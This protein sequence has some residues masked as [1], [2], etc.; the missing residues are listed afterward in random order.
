MPRP[1]RGWMHTLRVLTPFGGPG[2]S[3]E[4]HPRAAASSQRMLLYRF[5][6]IVACL[7]FLRGLQGLHDGFH[8]DAPR[9]TTEMLQG[10]TTGLRRAR[11]PDFHRNGT[12]VTANRTHA[13]PPAPPLDKPQH[14]P[15]TL[16]LRGTPPPRAVDR[17]ADDVPAKKDA[18]PAK[19]S[20]SDALL[21]SAVLRGASKKAEDAVEH[22]ERDGGRAAASHPV[23]ARSS[24][25]PINSTQPP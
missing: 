19:L 7:A 3:P 24:P 2:G 6:M 8:E 18:E 4:L 20:A 25:A 23:A 17:W 14:L 22:D 16:L 11:E 1:S 13:S 15:Q 21:Q 5:T 12:A 9:Q 10:S